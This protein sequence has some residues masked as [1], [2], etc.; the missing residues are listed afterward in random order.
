MGPLMGPLSEEET[1]QSKEFIELIVNF[2]KKGDPAAG[3]KFT[4]IWTKVADGQLSHYNFGKYSAAHK[5]LVYQDRMKFWNSLPVFWRN[6]ADLQNEKAAEGERYA[7]NQEEVAEE[8]VI[9]AKDDKPSAEPKTEEVIEVEDDT[10]EE[11]NAEEEE[12]VQ[13]ESILQEIKDEL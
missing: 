10:V 3:M 11:L 9:K 4:Q 6:V 5:G 1:E 13:V 7:E 2:A 12:E 8:E